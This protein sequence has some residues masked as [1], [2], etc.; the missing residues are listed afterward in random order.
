M[1]VDNADNESKRE[2]LLRA[3]KRSPV[4]LATITAGVTVV[5][6]TL[7]LTFGSDAV[8]PVV[9]GA[10]SALGI[11]FAYLSSQR[12]L[13]QALREA[14]S[15]RM[16]SRQASDRSIKLDLYEEIDTVVREIVRWAHIQAGP[17]PPSKSFGGEPNIGRPLPGED[18]YG[19]PAPQIPQRLLR[20]SNAVRQLVGNLELAASGLEGDTR[21][22]RRV[23]LDPR[24]DSLSERLLQHQAD[25]CDLLCETAGQLV[26][27]MRQELGIDD[28]VELEFV[29]GLDSPVAMKGSSSNAP[30]RPSG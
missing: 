24:P 19:L 15:A 23:P 26:R 20:A 5:A 17:M 29:R 9:T 7:V 3:V 30:A 16:A 12:Q 14:E 18:I 10:V 11:V 22:R 25:S 21:D 28:D 6:T 13:E 8:A 27:Q 4:L 2:Q 1:T